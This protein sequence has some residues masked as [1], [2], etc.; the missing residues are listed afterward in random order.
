TVA[1]ISGEFAADGSADPTVVITVAPMV[2][3]G[4]YPLVITTRVGEGART[5]TLLVAV[6]QDEAG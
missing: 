1:P 2:P 5:F 6:D 3:G 4:Y